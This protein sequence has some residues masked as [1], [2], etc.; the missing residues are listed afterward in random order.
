LASLAKNIRRNASFES[1]L[2][3]GLILTSQKLNV[4][5]SK[6]N[7]KISV[8]NSGKITITGVKTKEN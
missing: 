6:Q 2:L 4:N 3:P 5:E 8:F 1:E 7:C